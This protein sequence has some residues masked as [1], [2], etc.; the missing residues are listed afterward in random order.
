MYRLIM[1][2]YKGTQF[3]KLAQDKLRKLRWN[4]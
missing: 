4:Y 1:T 3:A 2:K